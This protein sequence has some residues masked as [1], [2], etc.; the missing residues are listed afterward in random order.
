F[1]Q[2][3]NNAAARHKTQ[4]LISSGDESWLPDFLYAAATFFTYKS[5]FNPDWNNSQFTNLYKRANVL[6]AGHQR[7]ADIVAMQQILMTDLPFIGIVQTGSPVP[8]RANVHGYSWYPDNFIR[9][10]DL[11]KS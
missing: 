2:Y 3:K 7:S 8:M 4:M 10:S 6:G 5:I 9:F 1:S 11:S